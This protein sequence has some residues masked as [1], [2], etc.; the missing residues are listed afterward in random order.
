MPVSRFLGQLIGLAGLVFL[1]AA[2]SASAAA[3]FASPTGSGTACSQAVPCEIVPAINEAKN[4]DDITIEP[5]T[6]GSPT[7]P[8]T[9]T[10]D[11]GGNTLAIHGQAGQPRPIIITQAGYGIELLGKNSSV[12]DLDIEDA[13]GQYGIYVSGVYNASI[14]HVISHVSAAAAVACYPSGTLTDSVCWSSGSDGIAATLLVLLSGSATLR[15]DTL[16]ASGSG[17]KAAAVDA[18][19]GTT[20]AINLVNSI[21]RGV[22]ADISA[23]T[24]SNP[25]STAT[26]SAEHSNYANVQISNEGG[27]STASV[28]PA[29]SG[30]NQTGAPAFVNATAGDFHELEGSPTIDAGVN[31]P[32]DGVTDLD[33]NPRAL[34][35]QILCSGSPSAVTDIGAY[36]FVPVAP[37]CPLP[38]PPET[39]I[40]KTKLNRK[41][42]EISFSFQA[43]G[44]AS[45]F[46]CKLRKPPVKHQRKPHS[47]VFG[48]YISEVLQ[49]S[50][51]RHL[52]V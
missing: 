30:T 24:D 47:G 8:L 13:T 14:D 33:G 34:P 26:V 7:K 23:S 38:P 11:D 22:G 52:Q 37:P 44:T 1:I 36:E 17:G 10:L 12:S 45:G 2:P 42:K 46:E 28:T 50:A 48:V 49:T 43:T 41:E 20:M 31:S 5:G 18:T 40:T 4:N 25:K 39:T 35:A 32:E 16:I 19:G 29:G 27:G 21:A 6:Y 3:R 51:A 15:N 9:L